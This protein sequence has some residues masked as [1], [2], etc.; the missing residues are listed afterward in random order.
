MRFSTL[1]PERMSPAQRRVHDA[2]AEIP[3]PAGVPSPC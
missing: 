2:I 1:E 3:L